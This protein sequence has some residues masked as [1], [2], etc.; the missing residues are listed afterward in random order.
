MATVAFLGCLRGGNLV[1]SRA[2]A[3][4]P[5]RQLRNSDVIC[6]PGR[7]DIEI[8]VEKTSQSPATSRRVRLYA[9]DKM[10]CSLDLAVRQHA[11]NPRCGPDDPFFQDAFGNA[12]SRSTVT[13]FLRQAATSLG[14]DPIQY[15]L[16]SPR[17]GAVNALLLHGYDF[18][19]T[20]IV[21]HWLS[22]AIFD[23]VRIQ[24]AAIHRVRVL[25][26]SP[27]R[28]QLDLYMCG[29]RP[30]VPTFPQTL[31]R[32]RRAKVLVLNFF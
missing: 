6:K 9:T 15:T 14:R 28:A 22:D 26:P 18:P 2:D 7:V 21:G 25:D 24:L 3:F 4:D 11:R 10:G 19:F 8:R 12:L 30:H 23:Y 16:H 20:K 13:A 29:T 5:L 17:I 32:E 27:R 1:P 31:P